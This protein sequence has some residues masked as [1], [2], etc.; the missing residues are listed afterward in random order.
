MTSEAT[1]GTADAGGKA[2]L[3]KVRLVLHQGNVIHMLAHHAP[4]KLHVRDDG[5]I[6]FTPWAPIDSPE[7]SDTILFM[8]ADAIAGVSYRL[9][10]TPRQIA[11]ALGEKLPDPEDA[12]DPATLIACLNCGEKNIPRRR[13]C[14]K[15]GANMGPAK[16]RVRR[17]RKA[18]PA[19]GDASAPKA[20]RRRRDRTGE[21]ANALRQCCHCGGVTPH[22]E[23]K[24]TH[25]C[26][27]CNKMF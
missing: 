13:G 27:S 8:R 14:R 19:E 3:V 23:A 15:C 1:E 16:P 5:M 21:A 25:R 17:A 2:P 7:Q 4:D 22:S 24:R 10:A 18:A 11:R 26:G 6:D 12:A 20:P 9:A